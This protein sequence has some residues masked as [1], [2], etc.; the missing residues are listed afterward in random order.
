MA[1]YPG[2]GN[3]MTKWPYSVSVRVQSVMVRK[4]G[5]RDEGLS[6]TTTRNRFFQDT[7]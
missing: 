4:S 5:Q 3:L 2:I 7:T 6:H 1:V